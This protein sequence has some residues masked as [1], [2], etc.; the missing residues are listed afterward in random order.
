VFNPVVKWGVYVASFALGALL[1][2]P[3]ES[4]SRT[5]VSLNAGP[6]ILVR[7]VV[8]NLILAILATVGSY[9]AVYRLVVRYR[10]TVVADVI[11]ETLEE[12]AEEILV[13]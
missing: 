2:G 3:V 13:E 12:I 8:G 1:L 11:D 4:A 6:D 10:D 7:L 9:A 5:A